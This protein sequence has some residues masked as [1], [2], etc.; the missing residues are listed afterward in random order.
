MYECIR[1]EGQRLLGGE[2]PQDISSL[3]VIVLQKSPILVEFLQKETCNY[4]QHTHSHIYVCVCV[5]VIICIHILITNWCAEN[6]Y[7]A[8]KVHTYVC[9]CVCV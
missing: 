4:I 7:I 6:I 9:V 3:L 1:V 5:C 2:D 8:L